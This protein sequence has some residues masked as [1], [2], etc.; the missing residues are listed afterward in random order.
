MVII[1]TLEVGS[2][3]QTYSNKLYILLDHPR[4][5]IEKGEMTLLSDESNDDTT[6]TDQQHHFKTPTTTT[7]S[8]TNQPSYKYYNYM[9][10]TQPG[11]NDTVREHTRK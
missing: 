6:Q 10:D 4:T 5:R 8:S 1:S 7:N 3:D 11:G 2:N 9:M